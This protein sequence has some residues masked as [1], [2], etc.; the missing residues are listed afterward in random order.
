M[1]YV[2]RSKFGQN[3]RISMVEGLPDLMNL[4]IGDFIE[5]HI[6]DGKLVL[7]KDTKKYSGID[8]E[9]D[10]IREKLREI[11]M[12]KLDELEAKDEDPEIVWEKARQR[13]LQDKAE[14]DKKKN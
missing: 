3:N 2:G 14:R 8:F 6:E 13:Y 5:F 1:V 10:E 7:Y 9:G 4:Q 11:E 12:K